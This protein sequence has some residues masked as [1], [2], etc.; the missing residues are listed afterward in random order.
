MHF[1][2]FLDSIT[3]ILLFVSTRDTS[4]FLIGFKAGH[5]FEDSYLSLLILYEVYRRKGAGRLK[6]L[7]NGP[8]LVRVRQ[9][10]A[11]EGAYLTALLTNSYVIYLAS[12]AVLSRWKD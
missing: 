11:D 10:R 1:T 7:R 5:T 3:E 6:E 9:I 4:L 8:V 2:N 12:A